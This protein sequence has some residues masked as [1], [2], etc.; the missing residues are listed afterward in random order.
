MS[1]P[2]TRFLVSSTTVLVLLAG[3]Q[4]AQ[5]QFHVHGPAPGGVHVAVGVG[6]G[7]GYPFHVGVGFGFGWYPWYPWGPYRYGWYPWYPYAY[8]FYPWYPY[9]FYPYYP[10]GFSVDPNTSSLRLEVKPTDTEVYVDGYLAGK[11][12]NFAGMFQRLRVQPGEHELVL[13]RD[14]YKTVQ[15]HLYLTPNSD[16]R[17]QYTMEKLAPGEDQGQ[18]PTPPPQSDQ[19]NANSVQARP[20]GPPPGQQEPPQP[21]PGQQPP[22]G[23]GQQPPPGYGQQPPPG[24]GRRQP[25]QEPPPA[26]PTPDQPGP[27]NFGSLSLL[28]QPDGA[29]ILI[30]GAAWP[31]PTGESRIVIQLPEGRHHIEIQKEGFAHYVE[32]V[33]IQKDHT[34]T[35][36][37]S[38]IRTGGGR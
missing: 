28:V 10:P 35:L 21:P 2:L 4:P 30:D 9:P 34:L 5:A 29:Q 23:Y 12:D 27:H 20:Y 6:Y 7:Y 25:Q 8:P 38:L 15:Q 37:V 22:P 3:P 24:Y 17:V 26:Q 11:V 36:N 32:D 14:G 1:A 13:Y 18:R 19:P 33:G 31:V 16:Q